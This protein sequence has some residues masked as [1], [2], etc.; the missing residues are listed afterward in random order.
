MILS[1]LTKSWAER[2]Q[3]NLS[4][5]MVRNILSGA[6]VKGPLSC[7]IEAIDALRAYS[8][9]AALCVDAPCSLRYIMADLRANADRVVHEYRQPYQPALNPDFPAGAGAD[10]RAYS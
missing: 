5:A 2:E 9:V 3:I 4:R 1:P 8:S 10:L 6:G 7:V